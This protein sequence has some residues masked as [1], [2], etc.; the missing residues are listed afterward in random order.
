M[1]VIFFLNNLLI[2]SYLNNSY[3]ELFSYQYFEKVKNKLIHA[4]FF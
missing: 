4:D 2:I 1:N 3:Y